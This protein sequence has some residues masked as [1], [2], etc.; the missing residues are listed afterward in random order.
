VRR[1]KKIAKA[2]LPDLILDAALLMRRYK[3]AHGRYPNL[4]RPKTFNE[5]ILYR[6]LFDKSPFLSQFADKLAVRS[7]VEERIGA[8]PLPEL[9]WTT[10]RP[11]DIPFERLPGEFVAKP[12]HGSGWV[13][14]VKDASRLDREDLVSTC[15]DWLSQSYYE[16]TR[17]R[18]YRDIVPRILIEE[19]IS[20]G[21]GLVPDDY[22]L[23]VF[24]GEVAMIERIT[25]RFQTPS[26]RFFD[27]SW[28]GIDI[29]FPG[30]DLASEDSFER[31]KKLE[32]MVAM[33]EA[34]GHGVDFVRVDLYHTD[35][36]VYFGEITASPGAGL[37]RFE[38]LS[39]D[40]DLGEL[41]GQ[42]ASQ[43]KRRCA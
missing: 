14:L 4:L 2:L 20:P 28:R 40:R 42:V 19:Y 36:K 35:D 41:W 30:F 1:V 5:R 16:M 29:S 17:E 37:D 8:D 11:S 26:N 15:E 10:S 13:R 3:E 38:P 31:P 25:G 23:Y 12:T 18:I 27:K 22:K 43:N 7:Y 32:E 24:G 6:N 9:Y 34:L 21:P 33:A 39:V